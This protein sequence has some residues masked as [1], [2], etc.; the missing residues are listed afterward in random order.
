MTVQ[1][2][3]T[4]GENERMKWK[5]SDG[6]GTGIEFKVFREVPNLNQKTLKAEEAPDFGKTVK[7]N[8]RLHPSCT[9]L[10]CGFNK[11]CLSKAL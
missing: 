6:K 10:S 3:C 7:G 4:V 8:T 11:V 1:P 2:E 5:Y 9:R